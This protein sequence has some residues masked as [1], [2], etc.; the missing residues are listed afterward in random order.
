MGLRE[1]LQRRVEKKI[2]PKI[3]EE[4]GNKSLAYMSRLVRGTIPIAG[5]DRVRKQVI[6]GIEGDL[7]RAIKKNP[8]ATI[9]SLIQDA[10]N[11][12]DYMALL[13]DLDMGEDH[14]RLLAKEA[15]QKWGELE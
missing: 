1:M 4:L 3:E 14:L 5:L 10:L 6:S 9:D 15:Q 8:S 7:R 11:T 2:R 12:P 13:K